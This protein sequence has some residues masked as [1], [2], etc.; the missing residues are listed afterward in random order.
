VTLRSRLTLLFLA[1]VQVTFLSAV[2][3]YWGLQSW[4]LVTDELVAIH[5]QHGRLGIVLDRLATQPA[6]LA[7]DPSIRDALAAMR[8]DAQTVDETERV[9]ALVADVEAGA[10]DPVRGAIRDLTDYYEAEVRR[11]RARGA[12]LGRASIWLLAGITGLVIASFLGFLAAIRAWLVEPIRALERATEVM[13]TRDLA[14][15][16]WRP[17]SPTTS[18]IP[19]PASAP[20]RR[21]RPWDSRRAIRG[22]RPSATS[23]TP[24][25]D[26]RRG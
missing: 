7:G 26:S 11:L 4:R 22:A 14:H 9:D 18:A 25:T 23:C 3:A 16:S 5:A 12:F 13:S 19:S 17:T 21:A 1:A 15:R 8:R 6:A 24:W 10:L 20:P 2:G